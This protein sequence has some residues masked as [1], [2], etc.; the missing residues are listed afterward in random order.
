LTGNFKSDTLVVD[1]EVTEI[2]K[3]KKTK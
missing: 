2:W 1:E 3:S